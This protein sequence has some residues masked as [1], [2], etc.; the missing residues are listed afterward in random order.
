MDIEA[1]IKQ[2]KEGIS[3]KK[4]QFKVMGNFL[5]RLEKSKRVVKSDSLMYTYLLSTFVKI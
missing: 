2:E 1:R 5:F 4:L 3:N